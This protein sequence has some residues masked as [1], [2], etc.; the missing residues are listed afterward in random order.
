[1][2]P[3]DLSVFHPWKDVVKRFNEQDL[4]T[5][6]EIGIFRRNEILKMHSLIFNQFQHD[7]FAAMWLYRW[8]KAGFYGVPNVPFE[9]LK[10]LLFN[11][12]LKWFHWNHFSIE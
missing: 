6:G 10:D 11:F 12:G 7:K 9:S 3:L 8:R 5:G 4:I 1:M 2:Q